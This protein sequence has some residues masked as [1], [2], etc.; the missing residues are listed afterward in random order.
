MGDDYQRG[1]ASLADLWY[2]GAV[3]AVSYTHLDVYKRQPQITDEVFNSFT[4]SFLVMISPN[5]AGFLNCTIKSTVGIP[6]VSCILENGLLSA[7]SNQS[8]TNSLSISKKRG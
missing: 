1:G 5:R 8:S 3:G 7:S 6:L 2:D 4:Q